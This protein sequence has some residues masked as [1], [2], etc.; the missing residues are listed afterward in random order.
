MGEE[1][2]LP[3]PAGPPSTSRPMTAIEKEVVTYSRVSRSATGQ[4]LRRTRTASTVSLSSLCLDDPELLDSVLDDDGC[5]GAQAAARRCGPCHQLK[6]ATYLQRP[7]N[8]NKV[9]PQVH[10]LY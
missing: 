10:F 7:D 8:A 5:L 2:E 3:T 1:Q 6:A 4:T 9:Q